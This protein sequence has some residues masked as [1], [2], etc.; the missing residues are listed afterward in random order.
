MGQL[1]EQTQANLQMLAGLRQQVEAN[2][3]TLRG[4]QDRL[5]VIERQIE[6]YNQDIADIAP[7]RQRDGTQSP[8]SRIATLQQELG[9]A[10]AMYT[11]KHP[12]V[13]R[14]QEE[15][16][17]AQQDLEAE[18]QK[19]ESE[20]AAKTSDPVFR[21]LTSDR[22]TARLRIAEL[23]RA[24]TD[25]QHQIQLYQARVEAAPMVEQQLATV[26]RDYDLE[27][28]QYQELST[29]LRT[30]TIAESVERNRSGEQFAVI[31]PASFPLTP[32]K[33]VLWRLLVMSIAAGTCLGGVLAFG[34][35]YLDRSVHDVRALKSE[36]DLPVLGEITHIQA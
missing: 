11:A 16:A 28:Q 14:L 34:R 25:M 17:N 1:P 12:E 2:A 3:T 18:R 5:T 4:E 7:S 32:T 27:K 6:T 35:E 22:D 21:Q 24:G 20:R 13:I 23:Q 26:Q 36:F 31:Y 30:A 19:P 33:P 10:R 9:A 29:K 15:L 8:E